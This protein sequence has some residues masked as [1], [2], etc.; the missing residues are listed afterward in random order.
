MPPGPSHYKD[1]N[2][3][4][5]GRSK[6]IL[7]RHALPFGDSNNGPQRT[8]I[9]IGISCCRQRKS[10]SPGASQREELVFQEAISLF[11]DYL[12]ALFAGQAGVETGM[13]Q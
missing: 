9:S 7:K 5:L 3:N 10:E 2:C 12:G 4:G 13:C 6:D 1:V 11:F 8:G